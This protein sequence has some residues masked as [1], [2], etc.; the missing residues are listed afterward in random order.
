MLLLR[1][2]RASALRRP[3]SPVN[4]SP[5][6][7]APCS[8]SSRMQDASRLARGYHLLSHS[9]PV[10]AVSPVGSM[11]PVNSLFARSLVQTRRIAT[12]FTPEP[13]SI[14]TVRTAYATAINEFVSYAEALKSATPDTS[15]G[16][17]SPNELVQKIL[18][19]RPYPGAGY[20]PFLKDIRMILSHLN[21]QPLTVDGFLF[22]SILT[23]LAAEQTAAEQLVE[24]H[25]QKLRCFPTVDRSAKAGNPSQPDA[26]V[27]LYFKSNKADV[28]AKLKYLTLL[29]EAYEEVALKMW[30]ESSGI[31]K[32]ATDYDALIRIYSTRGAAL[33]AIEAFALMKD[34]SVSPTVDTYAGLIAASGRAGDLDRAFAFFEEYRSSELPTGS[35]PYYEMIKAYAKNGKVDQALA[36]ISTVLAEDGVILDA[37]F[38]ETFLRSLYKVNQLDT[39]LQWHEHLKSK[40]S[41]NLPDVTEAIS[42]IAFAAAVDAGNF[43]LAET[44]FHQFSLATDATALCLFGT[45]ATTNLREDLALLVLKRLHDNR[46]SFYRPVSTFVQAL[47]ACFSLS[48]REAS[49]ACHVFDV[50]FDPEVSDWFAGRYMSSLQKNWSGMLS[51]FRLL[52]NSETRPE[53]KKVRGSLSA[54][55][56]SQVVGKDV[57]ASPP[58]TVE[59]FDDILDATRFHFVKTG[60]PG[61]RRLL[62]SRKLLQVVEEM[63]RRGL[64]PTSAQCDFIADYFRSVGDNRGLGDWLE[65][66]R[67]LGVLKGPLV[68]GERIDPQVLSKISSEMRNDIRKGELDRALSHYYDKLVPAGRIP[69]S[70]VVTLVMG[71]LIAR[72]RLDEANAMAASVEAALTRVKDP[73][74][75]HVAVL[76]GQVRGNIAS[77]NL[78]RA[79]ESLDILLFPSIKNGVTREILLSF[80]R[81]LAQKLSEN[82]NVARTEVEPIAISLFE[83]IPKADSLDSQTWEWRELLFLLSYGGRHEEAVRLYR[84]RM[85]TS[86]RTLG[87]SALVQFVRCVCDG[88][89]ISTVLFVID[90]LLETE[91]ARGRPGEAI[92]VSV[93]IAVEACLNRFQDL[94]SALML[95]DR[96]FRQSCVLD[97]TQRLL[98]ETVTLRV[99]SSL[100]A[101][102]VDDA[103]SWS[104]KAVT[105]GFGLPQ[106]TLELVAEKAIVSSLSDQSNVQS[107]SSAVE[108]CRSLALSYSSSSQSGLT[109]PPTLMP[110]LADLVGALY[111]SNDVSSAKECMGLLYNYG[112]PDE[113][114]RP[115]IVRA[116]KASVG[117]QQEQQEQQQQQQQGDSGAADREGS[118]LLE[119]L[120]TSVARDVVRELAL[121]KETQN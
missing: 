84:E 20:G 109:W 82:P 63:Q 111:R 83:T 9:R 119:P 62:V 71:E 99:Q 85:V 11:E 53:M 24:S 96:A 113:V 101:D 22:S 7:A 49:T 97:E 70:D 14:S 15:G 1:I 110:L 33:K 29:S 102:D 5:I 87:S 32:R 115:Y 45:M 12:S 89:D 67:A 41:E 27:N 100:E 105:R 38:F 46:G 57:K 107:L 106:S 47:D 79:K 61:E 2:L 23:V 72:G 35:S 55:F 43:Q 26:N 116:L 75:Y 120:P 17:Q 13:S 73:N 48:E 76:I 39:I 95:Y 37:S 68:K 104:S 42:E 64:K 52:K 34:A 58:V 78:I 31:V 44:L 51:F 54:A 77:Y 50:G 93:G 60:N 103:L 18:D 65:K 90:E 28:A 121:N 10:R 117:K 74:S 3:P 94:R 69:H 114:A 98:A 16:T 40:S 108:A 112:G 25:Q 91:S 81:T 8:S 4:A 30:E 59:D 6:V 88:A 21:G 19:S 80:C 92:S 66:M 86:P 36:V 56:F 118:I